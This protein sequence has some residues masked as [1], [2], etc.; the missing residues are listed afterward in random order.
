MSCIQYLNKIGLNHIEKYEREITEY[1]FNKLE[2]IENIN[3]LGPSPKVQPTRG[4]LASFYVK[5]IHANDIAEL[6]DNQKICIRSGHHCCQPLHR[7]Y[8]IKATA[9]ASLSF[10]TTTEEID[11]F[12]EELNSI[13]TFLRKY[14]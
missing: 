1:L 9:R 4:A 6:L 13:V 7:F 3:I 12:T 11:I 14:S 8:S 10:T 5:E 2:S